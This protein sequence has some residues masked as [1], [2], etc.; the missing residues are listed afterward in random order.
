METR[1]LSYTIAFDD[2]TGLYTWATTYADN[3][4]IAVDPAT[5]AD[6][7]GTATTFAEARYLAITPML[8]TIL[9]LRYGE[10]AASFA[11]LRL[12]E[13]L[14]ETPD[15]LDLDDPMLM[16]QVIWWSMH[17]LRDSEMQWNKRMG[18]IENAAGDALPFA[19]A[20]DMSY[21]DSTLY[22]QGFIAY[23]DRYAADAQKRDGR[24]KVTGHT[25]RSVALGI[26][27]GETNAAISRVLDVTPKMIEKYI[28]TLHNAFVQYYPNLA[29][30]YEAGV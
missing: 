29:L 17:Y 22:V 3:G 4:M 30:R 5:M 26:A 24:C 20:F 8:R 6:M 25:L 13:K 18:G 15:V 11:L 9:T 23:L 10:D 14:V 19:D 7:T 2:V 27:C 1:K 21:V 28:N 12:W 16:Q